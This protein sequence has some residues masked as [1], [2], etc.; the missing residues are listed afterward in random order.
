VFVPESRPWLRVLID[1]FAVALVVS[2][3]GLSA[4]LI[5]S[6][7]TPA[8]ARGEGNAQSR[9]M[10]AKAI[11]ARISDAIHDSYEGAGRPSCPQEWS[12]GWGP[13]EGA[14]GV[15]RGRVLSF[16]RVAKVHSAFANDPLIR[17][18][19]L[20]I[21]IRITAVHGDLDLQPGDSAVIAQPLWTVGPTNV[22]SAWEGVGAPLLKLSL[23]RRLN[24]LVAVSKVDGDTIELYNRVVLSDGKATALV[25]T[26]P[27]VNPWGFRSLHA[28]ERRAATALTEGPLDPTAG[29]IT[30]CR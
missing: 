29:E 27:A 8:A 13:S 26:E 17:Q 18:A 5:L 1:R 4:V 25:G 7:P 20:G 24:A 11:A 19:T 16:E 10:G 15:V 14:A 28:I 23:P 30:R 12:R 2:T 21:R 22:E 3:L 6:D 9:P